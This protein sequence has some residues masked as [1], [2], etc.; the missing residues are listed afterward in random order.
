MSQ[1]QQL[2]IHGASAPPQLP[3]P[4]TYQESVTVFGQ[5]YDLNEASL[6]QYSVVYAKPLPASQN[7]TTMVQCGICASNVS[8]AGLTDQFFVCPRC[9]TVQRLP[10]AF[11]NNLNQ[12]PAQ[13]GYN[14]GQMFVPPQ[15]QNM[16]QQQQQEMKSLIKPP[17][18]A[19]ATGNDNDPNVNES[20]GE[21]QQMLAQQHMMS[22]HQDME[23]PVGRDAF[24]IRGFWIASVPFV[25]LVYTLIVLY[26][27][28]VKFESRYPYN[29]Q[30]F[31]TS[32]GKKG[33][34]VGWVLFIIWFP[35]FL[36]SYFS[37]TAMAAL[38]GSAAGLECGTLCCL[39]MCW[40]LDAC[41]ATNSG[42]TNTY[43]DCDCLF[44]YHVGGYNSGGGGG[45][46]S[47]AG[48]GD[49]SCCCSCGDGGGGG[50]GCCEGGGCGDVGVLCDGLCEG[51]AHAFT[52][53]VNTSTDVV[54]DCCQP[55]AQNCDGFSLDCDCGQCSCPDL[56]VNADCD[57]LDCLGDLNCGGVGDACSN[58]N[59]CDGLGNLDCG[60][61]DCGSIDCGGC[62]CGG[63][64]CGGC[65]C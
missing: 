37:W 60:D 29:M 64:D 14:Q 10:D 55:L 7:T 40:D 32:M 3:P 61:C 21:R 12:A 49:S 24:A 13:M 65:D 54:G 57:N 1:Q 59:I 41:C 33:L 50:N 11:V 43:Y 53:C 31:D 22:R 44:Y 36:S 28:N 20:V 38:L 51:V 6:P 8:L 46:S 35:I 9:Q 48:G 26:Q 4:P 27:I 45:G 47:G 39:C 58:C 19:A 56:N 63:C 2:N 30:W 52:G 62:D 25:N 18:P 15:K 16:Q 17:R 5:K 34:T 42:G 23:F